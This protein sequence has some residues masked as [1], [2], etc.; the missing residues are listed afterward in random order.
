MNGP[1]SRIRMFLPACARCRASVPP[2]APVPITIASYSPGIFIYSTVSGLPARKYEFIAVG[3]LEFRH[4]SPHLFLRFLR[5]FH[6]FGLENLRRRKD[7]VAPEGYR[8][9]TANAV[10]VTFGREQREGSI[11]ARDE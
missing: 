9:E 11:G 10:F 2:P 6:A 4:R 7:V 8:L 5:Q 1:R 3:V